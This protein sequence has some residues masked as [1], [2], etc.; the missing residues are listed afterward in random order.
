MLYSFFDVCISY[1]DIV[2]SLLEVEIGVSHTKKPYEQN[3]E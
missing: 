3:E 2:S 1:I